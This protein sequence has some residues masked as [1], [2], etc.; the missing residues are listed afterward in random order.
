MDGLSTP[1]LVELLKDD[2]VISIWLLV[3]LVL[4]LPEDHLVVPPLLLELPQNIPRVMR[5]DPLQQVLPVLMEVF[6]KE[7]LPAESVA[8]S[9]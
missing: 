4:L 8:T 3:P 6:E 1:F 2:G 5:P 9:L 7:S